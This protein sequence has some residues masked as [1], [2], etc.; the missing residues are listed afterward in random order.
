VIAPTP[1]PTALSIDQYAEA[2]R[3]EVVE[4]LRR[5]A[6]PLQG[7]RVVHVNSTRVGGGVAEI[8]S[9]LTRLMNDLGI[10]T[11]WE[12]VAGDPAFFR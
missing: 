2:C 9:W 4:Q 7:C 6:K 1:A 8:L 12:V 5:M 10:L 11:S 3:P